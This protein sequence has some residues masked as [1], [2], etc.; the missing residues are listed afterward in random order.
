MNNMIGQTGALHP[1]LNA[2]IQKEPARL[3]IDIGASSYVC[4][5]VIAKL[6]LKPIGREH[7]IRKTNKLHFVKEH[8]N[9]KNNKTIST[10]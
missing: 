6:N 9:W 2:T 7:G 3:M 10:S 4:M 1:S 5:E 8:K